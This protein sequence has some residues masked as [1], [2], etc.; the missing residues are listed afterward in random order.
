MNIDLFLGPGGLD[1]DLRNPRLIVVRFS[2][3]VLAKW[4]AKGRRDKT[5]EKLK[6]ITLD[7]G[8]EVEVSATMYT[9]YMRPQWREEK[10]QQ[11]DAKRLLSS[12]YEYGTDDGDTK[13]MQDYF[14]DPNPTPEERMII[15]E[16]NKLLYEA[17]SI[18]SEENRNLINA[19]FMQGKS[20]RDYA[21]EIGVARTTINYKRNKAL[22]EM[23]DYMQ[24]HF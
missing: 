8:T 13:T 20:E 16:E 14:I 15:E 12:D 9:E 5:M 4:R 11:R 23:R 19:L 7:D 21:E 17:I 22:Q 2:L 1:E 18:L 3:F 24:K 6:K 10:C